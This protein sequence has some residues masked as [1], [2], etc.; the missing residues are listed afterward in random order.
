ME[1]QIIS[2]YTKANLLNQINYTKT[3]NNSKLSPEKFVEYLLEDKQNKNFR[4][5]SAIYDDSDFRLNILNNKKILIDF[6][7][8]HPE[9]AYNILYW[10]IHFNAIAPRNFKNYTSDQIKQIPAIIRDVI[11]FPENKYKL[12]LN[13]RIDETIFYNIPADNIWEVLEWIAQNKPTKL[14]QVISIRSHYSPYSARKILNHYSQ[15]EDTHSLPTALI[16]YLDKINS[17]RESQKMNALTQSKLKKQASLIKQLSWED[18]DGNLIQ[19]FALDNGIKIYSYDDYALII[20][21]FMNANLSAS[22]FCKKFKISSVEG[23][24]KMCEKF[25]L[26]NPE[27][28]E[29]YKTNSE[30]KSKEAI[31]LTTSKITDVATNRLAVGEMLDLTQHRRSLSTMIKIGTSTVDEQTLLNFSNLI[32]Q[33]YYDRLN[34]YDPNA[35]DEQNLSKYL[36]PTEIKFLM[37]TDIAEKLKSGQN[38]QFGKIFVSAM[39]PVYPKLSRDER[40]KIVTNHSGIVNRLNFYNEYFNPNSYLNG[41]SYF[42]LNN[43]TVK[44]NKDMLDMAYCF[45]SKNKLFICENTMSKIMKAIAL[46]EI[47]NKTE[48]EEYKQELQQRISKKISKCNSLEEYL[49]QYNEME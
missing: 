27:F 21:Y 35:L 4:P 8:N 47:Q 40:L 6:S 32:I 5:S 37:T 39:S 29:F 30:I 43:Q 7:I 33:Y 11:T 48:T 41:N 36:S 46:G 20:K 16:E 25:A 44:I 31:V 45:A 22:E 28:A 15:L 23:F 9:Y 2:T 49:N 19:F 18:E 24:R 26:A 13:H 34:S 12:I 38:I 1:E 3:A 42:T 17:L 14:T 10:L